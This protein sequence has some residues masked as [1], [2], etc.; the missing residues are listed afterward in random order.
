MLCYVILY[1]YAEMYSARADKPTTIKFT[2]MAEIF[3]QP[4]PEVFLYEAFDQPPWLLSVAQL[5]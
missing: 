1:L 3:F 2:K 5:C 4:T